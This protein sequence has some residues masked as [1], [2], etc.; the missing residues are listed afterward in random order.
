MKTLNQTLAGSLIL[1][2]IVLS[3]CTS[4]QVSEVLDAANNSSQE[5]TESHYQE[6]NVADDWAQDDFANEYVLAEPEWED[7]YEQY[8]YND[9]RSLQEG[10]DK[11]HVAGEWVVEEQGEGPHM[12]V[13]LKPTDQNYGWYLLHSGEGACF[14]TGEYFQ[15]G[16][17]LE[18]FSPE[19]P[20]GFALKIHNDFTEMEMVQHYG[21]EPDGN[22]DHIWMTR[23][24]G[25]DV[26]SPE[27]YCQTWEQKENY[28]HHDAYYNDSYVEHPDYSGYQEQYEYDEYH[29]STYVDYDEAPKHIIEDEKVIK[30]VDEVI[31]SVCGDDD[32]CW[33][34]VRNEID[35]NLAALFVE[36]KHLEHADMEFITEE[37]WKYREERLWYI[38]E[39]FEKF[40]QLEQKAGFAE[41]E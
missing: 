4:E 22:G 23:I 20:I 21:P 18:V 1:S 6:T 30:H 5:Q 15:E 28:E 26:Q 31:Y 13:V 11:W 3:G 36:F 39:Q 7:G 16:D 25:N 29:D 37:E 41:H 12:E 35:E 17:F 14:E 9:T 34:F 38:F 27:S 33:R 8:A 19:G 40:S 10:F 2:S 24:P 32:E